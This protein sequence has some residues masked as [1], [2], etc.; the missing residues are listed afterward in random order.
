MPGWGSLDRSWEVIVGKCAGGLSIRVRVN[1]LH[2]TAVA[3]TE[4]HERKRMG[5][6]SSAVGHTWYSLREGHALLPLW[7][8][9]RLALGVAAGGGGG[10]AG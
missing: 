6:A 4:A 5:T 9:P 3:G 2:I 7:G 1:E 8:G 10:G